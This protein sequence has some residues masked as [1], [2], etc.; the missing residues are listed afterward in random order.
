MIIRVCLGC[1]TA[2]KLEIGQNVEAA[3]Y[4]REDKGEQRFLRRLE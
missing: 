3:I 1:F 4:K 2:N